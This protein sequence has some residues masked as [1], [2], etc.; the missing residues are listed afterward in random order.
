MLVGARGIWAE[1]RGWGGTLVEAPGEVCH[2]DGGAVQV[3]QQENAMDDR[4]VQPSPVMRHYKYRR[5][6]QHDQPPNKPHPYRL[7]PREE[8]EEVGEEVAAEQI[9]QQRSGHR[10]GEVEHLGSPLGD[11]EGRAR[12]KQVHTPAH[13]DDSHGQNVF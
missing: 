1:L 2:V 5:W 6:R 13:L 3:G 8:G 11:G 7:L 9:E 4:E 12:A 10:E